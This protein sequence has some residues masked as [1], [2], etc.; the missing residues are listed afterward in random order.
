MKIQEKNVQKKRRHLLKMMASGAVSA[1]FIN[2]GLLTAS[3]GFASAATAATSIK[4]VIFVFIPG[5]APGGASTSITP[6]A[7]FNLK[8]ASAPLEPVKNECVFF[9]NTDMDGFGGHG[10]PQ[11]SLGGLTTAPKT[12]DL[13]LGDVLGGNTPFKS[14]QLGVLSSDT[15]ISTVNNWTR[16]PVI[17]D[18]MR[19]FEILRTGSALYGTGFNQQQK[20]LDINSWVVLRV[21][22]CRLMRM[23]SPSCRQNFLLTDLV[24]VA[25]CN[26]RAGPL[27][28]LTPMTAKILPAYG[29]YKP[30]M[31]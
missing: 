7:A 31:L 11:N 29:N 20:Q 3:A 17:T 22:V 12:I 23:P 8:P 25:T 18:P 19:A 10:L 26:S 5:G 6:D 14:I 24:Q 1:P 9:S 28:A 15:S 4:N 13:A 27:K 16:T 30:T 2:T 21:R